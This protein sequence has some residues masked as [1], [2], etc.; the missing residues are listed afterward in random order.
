MLRARTFS[1][2]SLLGF[3]S[4]VVSFLVGG[5]FV[6]GLMPLIGVRGACSISWIVSAIERLDIFQNTLV[7]RRYRKLSVLKLYETEM[8][9]GSNDASAAATNSRQQP[10][11]RALDLCPRASGGLEPYKHTNDLSHEPPEAIYGLELATTSTIRL[12]VAVDFVHHYIVAIQLIGDSWVALF[13]QL[14]LSSNTEHVSLT[15]ILSI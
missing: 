4:S 12:M 8:I 13:S 7:H 10:F 6:S 15:D 2:S 5:V 14:A 11:K 9:A 3:T 1:A